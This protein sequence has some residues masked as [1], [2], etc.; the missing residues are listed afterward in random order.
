MRLLL[1]LG[2]LLGA[3]GQQRP[4]S[5]QKSLHGRFLH[6]TDFHPDAFYSEGADVEDFCHDEPD[7]ER[8][9]TDKKGKEKVRAGH[10]GPP[11]GTDCD[12]PLSLVNATFAF[13]SRRLLPEGI[14]FVVWTGDSA[15]HDNDNRYPRTPKQ[16]YGLNE[17]MIK[18]MHHVFGKDKYADD[19]I[20]VVPTVGN[21]DVFPHNVMFAGPG[22]KTIATYKNLWKSYV[23][24]EQGHTFDRGAY[25]HVKVGPQLSV[26]S[27]NTLY[28][29][30]KNKAVDDCS[31]RDEPGSLQ[32]EWLEIQF[33]LFRAAKTKVYVIGHVPPSERQW[34]DTCYARYAELIVN[35]RDLVIG[36]LF[37]HVNVDY[38]GFTQLGQ[39]EPGLQE[40]P[41][42]AL[43][44]NPLDVLDGLRANYDSLPQ[45]EDLELTGSS[46]RQIDRQLGH[47]AVIN[48]HPSVVPNYFPT[49]RVYHYETKDSF[50]ADFASPD[51]QGLGI[52]HE[53]GAVKHEKKKNKHKKPK[54]PQPLP[55]DSLGPGLLKQR[56]SPLSYTQYYL[57]T[58]AANDAHKAGNDTFI[59]FEVEYRSNEAPY[60]MKDLTLSEWIKLGN[61]L[62]GLSSSSPDAEVQKKKHKRKNKNK[63][64][65]KHK[66]KRDD[67]LWHVFVHRAFV[68][69]GLEDEYEKSR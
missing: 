34:Y 61:R 60:K 8:L 65:K 30:E 9:W 2:L 12:T 62:S 59:D 14:D 6:L 46:P 39:G 7:S 45:I 52:T 18:N 35:Y 44:G 33:K 11:P 21:N 5:A 55:V 19:F 4:F 43:G 28:F 69:T 51:D 23:P 41:V 42:K 20:P 16:I 48:V 17:M 40:Q 66:T 49:M 36:Q 54:G 64:K 3:Y 63:K 32:L 13:V 27:L 67:S 58:T 53:L 68:G 37:G 57:N 31:S 1:A 26:V 47:L 24:P 10:Y 22:S 50:A 25:F 38:F 29:Y 56:Y 15:R